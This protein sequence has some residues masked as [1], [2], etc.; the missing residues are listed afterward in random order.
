MRIIN[1]K[2]ESEDIVLDKITSRI[3]KLCYNLESNVIDPIII[4]T[5]VCSMIRDGITTIELDELTANICMNLSLEHPD[6]GTLGS[7]I[8]INNH[9]KNVR[10]SFSEAMNNLYNHLDVHKNHSPLVSKEVWEFSQNPE[11]KDWIEKTLKPKRDYLID[12]FGF[13]TLERSYLLRTDKKIQETPQYMWMRVA[14]GIHGCDKDCTKDTYNLMSQKY[15][16]HATPTLFHSGT[17]RPQMS[18]CFLM[19]TDDSVE[20]IYKTI[21]DTAMISKW[22]GGIGL[23][24]GNIR[25]RN[26]FIRKTGGYSD[27]ILPMLKVYNHT[28]RYINQSGK[29]NGSFAMYLP[30]WHGDIFEF[31]DAKKNHGGEEERARDLFYALW[32]SDLFMKRVESN[33]MW[34]L[35][36]PDRCR[37]LNDVYGDEFEKLYIEYES[38]GMYMKQIK[39]QELWSH[40]L[41]TQIETGTPYMLYKD[42][43]NKKSNQ[44]NLGTIKS[45]NLCCV[46]GDTLLLTDK[47][48]EVIETLE[49]KIVNVWNGKEFSE[50]TVK[51]TND[52]AELLNIHLS[53]GSELNC[54]KYHKFY[55]QEKYP[56]FN[57]KQDI[58]KSKNVKL[59][60][61]QHLKTGMKLIKCD[62]PVIDNEKILESSYTN[63]FFSGDGTYSNV[64]SK[65][66]EKN[67]DY[68]AL[69]NKSYC[70][71]H[72]TLQQGSEIND[73]C[74]GTC[75]TPKPMV[76]LYQEKIK[77][78][79]HLDYVSTG[80]EKKGKLNVTL[81]PNLKE[82]FFV[83]MNYSLKSKL[84]WFS[85]YC[86]ADGTIAINGD[87]QSLQISCIHK[88]F[89]LKIKLML[90]TCGVASKVT[91]N[92]N[93]R[94]TLLPNGKGSK[95]L[96]NCKTLY[97]LL[98]GSNDLQRLV[99]LGFSSK[100]LTIKK[101]QPQRNATQFVKIN[102]II[103]KGEVSK[104]YCFT[105]K[106]RHA[107]IFNGIITSQCEI[108]EYSDSKEYAVCNLA[109]IALP[110]YL[111]HPSLK[112]SVKIYSKKN[113]NYCLLTKAFF[114]ERN[115]DYEEISVD[116]NHLRQL[117]FKDILDKEGKE[118]TTVPQIF[119]NN[120]RIGGYSELKD[121]YLP[122]FDHK[123]LRSVVHT[124]V[125]N[126]NKIIDINFYPVPETKRS[127][128][129]HRP[130][131]IGVQGLAD[132][133]AE[134]HYDFEGEKARRLN[135]EIFETIYYSSLE[136]SN[137]LSKEQGPYETFKGSP[138]SKGI[139][140]FDMWK[141]ETQ[142]RKN[143]WDWKGLKESIKK[144]GIRNSLLVAPMPTASTSQ[145]LGCNECFEPFTSNA[146]TRRTLAGEFTVV[147]HRLL[148]KLVNMGMWSEVTKYRLI[149]E[150]GSV[151]NMKTLPEEIRKVFKTSWDI[152]QKTIIEMAADRGRFICQSQSL[153]IHLKNPTPQLL[154]KVHFYGWK[155]GLKT[156]SYYIRAKSVKNAQNFTIDHSME[157]KIK[158]EE[159]EEQECLMCGS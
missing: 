29:R 16:T 102:K 92:M 70:K 83:P 138:A 114:K 121:Q 90:Q 6:W 103:D 30:D 7:R 2:G 134:L 57:M 25:C 17:P 78:L 113:C 40:I 80:Q 10:Q 76:S 147:N 137:E 14:L 54:T 139:L 34:S 9:Q 58:I 32:V 159:E 142:F 41:G 104:T 27:G 36:C 49:D 56:T 23:H 15:F 86:D 131:G 18:S 136:M 101:H 28:A 1:R 158:A 87:N 51:Q 63:G 127:N 13:K 71:R 62:Y 39:A 26:S 124:I 52:S 35:M 24:I 105:E 133:F 135:K 79:P 118:I 108:I 140:Q 72:I 123:K 143:G 88:E 144:H 53:D 130:I 46:R 69:E 156:G 100:R 68:K 129:R 96:Y 12:Y 106:K 115:I 150:R 155:K 43:C 55:I 65:D 74:Q 61:A 59:I 99:Q 157:Q 122:V 126:L 98:V 109:S 11:N 82:K 31:L 117:F 152:K 112:G 120:I 60:E 145:I 45:S 141:G 94:E 8:A 149:K 89:L 116:D 5:K 19:G 85:G 153:N 66:S 125:K 48:H 132:L 3:K 110:M 81:N 151:Q 33:G 128:M 75:Y 91:L 38:K 93:E 107:G 22:A 4:S 21:S 47:G 77:L 64:F 73:K 44:K 84:G 42:P 50:V 111:K 119:I 146:Y 97:R 148:K 37:N 95:Q 20:G 67:C 154:T